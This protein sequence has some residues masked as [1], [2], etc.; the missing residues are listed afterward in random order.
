MDS[1]LSLFFLP[2]SIH[3]TKESNDRARERDIRMVKDNALNPLLE[4]YIKIG[5]KLQV[6]CS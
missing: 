4:D 2:S 1:L 5:F 3:K 6:R